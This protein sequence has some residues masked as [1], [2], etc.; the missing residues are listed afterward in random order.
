MN[1]SLIRRP[2]SAALLVVALLG[3][4][5]AGSDLGIGPF[6]TNAVTA[7]VYVDRDGSRSVTA[8]VD[9]VIS[10]VRVQLRAKG[11]GALLRT[12]TTTT[13]GIARFD[14]VPLGEYTVS[15]D[16]A[17][18]GDSLEISAIDSSNIRVRLADTNSVVLIRLAFPEVTIREIRALPAGQRVFLRGYILA[19][20]QSFRDTTSHV[21]DSSG[22]LRL[23]RV[24]LRAGTGNA[25]GD[26]VTIL[27][28]S[29][30]RA[31]Q[32]TLD[33]ATIT[34][35]GARPAP[36]PLPV[37]TATA[38]SASA[39]ILDAG[40]VVVTGAL[41]SDTLTMA[42]DYHVTGSDGT[43]SLVVVLDGNLNFN[44]SLFRP[45]RTMNVRGVLVPTGLGTWQLK[46][47]DVFDV[48]VF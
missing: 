12:A 19:G 31:G 45:G 7:L 44:R 21:A 41:I 14:D 5:N 1:R 15:V 33:L 27:G 13:L 26:S 18:I 4:E 17:T 48:Q 25:P 35:L 2:G 47:R 22:A 30:S 11:G 34:R 24:S 42:P 39:G 20:V 3:C 23:T 9:T 16:A 32:P 8:S 29:S 38:A 37:S 36:V 40:L 10:G 43:G 6:E 28:T 46:P